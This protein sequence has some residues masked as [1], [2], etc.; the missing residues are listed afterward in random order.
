MA[1]IIQHP[2]LERERSAL[3]QIL[4]AA[5]D[6]RA[7]E[8]APLFIKRLLA[9]PDRE[10]R[11]LVLAERLTR[12]D[13][14]LCVSLLQS[15]LERSLARDPRAQE[16]LLDLTTA[17]PLMERLGYHR[18]RRLYELARR[19]D[20]YALARMLL[21]PETLVRREEGPTADYENKYMQDTSLGWRKT[22]AKGP[23]R[24]TLDRLMW[25]RN[26]LVVE[27]LLN[28]PRIT[29]RDVIRIA[30]MRPANPECLARVFA[31]ERWLRRYRVKVSLALN[32][33]TPLDI[34]L[35][36]LP[37][38]MKQELLYASRTEK[39]HPSIKEAA[40]EMVARRRQQLEEMG[41]R[42][43]EEHADDASVEIDLDAIRTELDEWMAP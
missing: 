15:L 24:G 22:L 21:S 29:E 10:M 19:R 39:I 28:N 31:H 33:D 27:N 4:R 18:A 26:P 6:A 32:P 34:A 37:Q 42:W 20:Q 11:S 38:L 25:D 40:Q 16:A 1:E 43:E 36:L 2:A 8:A 30:A 13:V 7:S 35:T 14:H 17:R 9:L 41:A 5:V 3:L 23:D 12:L